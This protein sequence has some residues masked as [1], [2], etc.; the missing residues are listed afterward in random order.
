MFQGKK[1]LWSLLDEAATAKKKPLLPFYARERK[2]H[3]Y[4]VQRRK[5]T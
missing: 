4:E 3:D 5:G 2:A 1:K